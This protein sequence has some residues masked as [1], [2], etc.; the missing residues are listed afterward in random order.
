MAEPSTRT[1]FAEARSRLAQPHLP[2]FAINHIVGYGQS[3]SIGWEGWPALSVTQK[4][5]SLMLGGSVRPRDPGAADWQPVG[6]AAFEPL[7]ATVQSSASGEILPPE[8][9]ATLPPGDVATGET[10]LEAA[11]NTW[12]RR[13]L[14]ACGTAASPRRLL[15]S[16]CGVNGRNIEALSA[17]ASPELFN[18]LRACV[19]L[20]RHVAGE[21]G[22]TYG[23]GALLLLHGEANAWGSGVSDPAGYAAALRRLHED[24]ARDVAQDP[25][26]PMFFYQTG[27]AY[28]S[29]DLGVA[30]G[31]LDVGL[32]DANR[33]LVGP[34]YPY[35]SKAAGHLDA[36][37]YR[38]LGAQ[39][40]KIMYRV[41]TR[42]E[43]WQPLHPRAAVLRGRTV[44]V[45][46]RVPVPPLKLSVP[47]FLHER[48]ALPDKGF[49]VRDASGPVEIDA[50]ALDGPQRVRID[51]ARPPG[52]NARLLYADSRNLGRGHLHDSDEDVAYD[53]YECD[54][55]RGHYP[56]ANIPG[57][58]GRP[59]PL[60]N[61]CVAFNIA[62]EPAP[63]PPPS[64]PGGG[65]AGLF[66][67]RRT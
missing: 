26:V 18:R 8:V 6:P 66:G 30:Q 17:G 40:G 4:Q 64:P 13:M 1:L 58:V 28:T 12:R 61:W 63:A 52:P 31:Q 65:L 50:V 35:P 22:L 55:A 9:V 62:L 37:G 10:V 49:T 59:Y 41:L 2:R 47:L 45:S 14:V 19:T 20:A 48:R 60:A 51:L 39:F 36:N 25:T 57:L 11:L 29:D 56:D 16:T 27:G 46:F 38:W 7:R 44:E 23:V 53:R 34:V 24:F 3:L 54:P 43:P 5:D 21:A 15:A 42:G 32:A 33:F 67:W